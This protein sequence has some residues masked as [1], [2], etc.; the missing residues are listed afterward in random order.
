VPRPSGRGRVDS[1]GLYDVLYLSS[2]AAGAIAEAFGRLVPWTAS[3]LR[4]PAM[5][6]ADRAIARFELA[7]G[8]HVL[9]LDDVDSLRE[10]GIRP[11]DVVT[12]DREVTQ[13][14][15]LRAFRLKRWIGV[16]WWSYYDPR[17]YAYGLWDR[18]QLTVNGVEPLSLDHPAVVEAA[19]VLRRPRA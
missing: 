5:P 18:R 8:A 16:R 9:D 15:A 4:V 3:M 19:T 13:A 14:W 12:R 1:P 7:E 17:W 6:N 11:S 2:A 10:L